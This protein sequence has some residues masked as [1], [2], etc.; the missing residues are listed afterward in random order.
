MGSSTSFSLP[1]LEYPEAV[2]S[3]NSRL[4]PVAKQQNTKKTQL[5]CFFSCFSLKKEGNSACK[6]EKSQ[7]SPCW[8]AHCF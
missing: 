7:M 4:Q 2:V 6:A 3:Q 5:H 8:E 1:L